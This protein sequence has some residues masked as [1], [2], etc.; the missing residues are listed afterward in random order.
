[1]TTKTRRASPGL[2]TLRTAGDHPIVRSFPEGAVIVFD[3][4]LRYLSAGGLGLADFGLSREMLEGRTIFE[5]FDASHAAQIEVQYRHALAGVVSTYDVPF[6]DRTFMQRLGPMRNADGTIVAGMGFTQ[7]VTAARKSEQSLRESEERFR[8]AFEQATVAE[9]RFAHTALHDDLTGLPNR[10]LV[11][12]RLSRALNRSERQGGVV[13]LFCDLDGFKRVNDTHGHHAGDAV[14]VEAATRMVAATRS[15]DTVG[16]MGGDEFVVICGVSAGDDAATLADSVALRIEQAVAEP[17]VADGTEHRV[18][19]SIGIRLADQGD[20]AAAVL[21]DADAAMYVAKSQ[22]KNGHALYEPALLA[23]ALDR[24]GIER[25]IRRA[26]QDDAI[27]VF[28]Q[29]VVEP[30]SGRVRSVEAL[31]RVPD[32]HGGYLNT[33]EAVKVAEQ[34]GIISAL[35]ER[36]LRLACTQVATWRRN[37]AHADL[38]LAVNRGAAEIGRPGFYDRVAGVLAT[39]GLDPLAL[40]IEITETALL[41]IAPHTVAD[42]RRLRAAGMGVAIDDFGTG[43]ASLR[44]LATLPISCLK[45][46]QTFTA[47]LP[48]DLT[49]TT[50]L[51]AT[52]GLAADLGMSCVVEGVETVE[53]LDA[54]PDS[55]G[56]LVQGYLHARP[57][58]GRVELPTHYDSH[59]RNSPA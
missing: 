15:G 28:F 57:Q 20:D 55:P 35:D 39:T 21:R 8:L 59:V 13:V 23:Q 18:T 46:D 27:E 45:V 5:V 14:L 25:Q 4:D 6:G 53:Q 42:L 2:E 54:L 34:T 19:A 37:P 29:P 26:L 16:R 50:I 40:T 56:L 9:E 41:D 36:V 47:G 52:V 51:R 17:V 3:H 12:D 32:Q 22:G 24:E 44:Y 30:R 49:C 31:L 11:N 7:D 33:L 58:P 48:H 43:Y 10:R 38:G 1:V